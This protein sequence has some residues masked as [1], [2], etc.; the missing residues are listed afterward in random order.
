MRTADETIAFGTAA[1][2]FDLV[3]VNDEVDRAV[4]AINSHIAEW[5]P[6]SFAPQATAG[7]S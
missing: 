4:A 1:G 7:G 5:F 6:N 2:T 3:V